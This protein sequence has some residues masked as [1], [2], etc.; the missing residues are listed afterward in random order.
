MVIIL[1]TD[2]D[3]E[4]FRRDII[5]DDVLVY[6]IIG[7]SEYTNRYIRNEIDNLCLDCYVSSGHDIVNSIEV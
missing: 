6:N 7:Y 2:M 4:L 1:E 3:L 5:S